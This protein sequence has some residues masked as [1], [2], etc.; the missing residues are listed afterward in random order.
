M[1]FTAKRYSQTLKVEHNFITERCHITFKVTLIKLTTAILTKILYDRKEWNENNYQSGIFQPLQLS[2]T[3]ER[4]IKTF[5][6]TLDA[7]GSLV[8]RSKRKLTAIMNKGGIIKSIRKRAKDIKNKHKTIRHFK[9]AGLSHY[10]S[11]ITLHVS[12]VNSP[13]LKIQTGLKKQHPVNCNLQKN[14]CTSKETHRS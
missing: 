13:N 4:E 7:Y 8:Y 5:T 11:V 3:N 14:Y 10:L 12:R 1:I 2:F 6:T 9:T